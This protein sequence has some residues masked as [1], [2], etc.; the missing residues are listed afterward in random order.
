ML[1]YKNAREVNVLLTHTS[2]L[3]QYKNG[4]KVGVF[5]KKAVMFTYENKFDGCIKCLIS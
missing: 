4:V 2:G 1:L 3:D 5:L